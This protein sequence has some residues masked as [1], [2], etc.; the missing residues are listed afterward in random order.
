L[1]GQTF[2]DVEL[3]EELGQGGMGVVYK[4][5]QKSL[6]RLVAVKL[7]LAEHQ[8][9]AVRLARFQAEARAAASLNHSNIV[10][11]YQVGECSFGHYFA[12]EYIDGETLETIIQR[13]KIGIPTAVALMSKVAEAVHYAHSKGIVHRDLKPGNIMLDR[14][15]RPVVMD[16]GIAKFVGKSSRLTLEGAIMGTP[17]FM[18]PEQAGEAHDLVGPLSDVY[19]L[20]AVLY[21]LL[22]GRVPYDEGSTLRT[23]L[24]V[25]GPD[26]PPTVRSLR[27]QVPVELDQLCMKCLSKR[28]ADRYPSAQALAQELRRIRAGL[29]KAKPEAPGEKR[30]GRATMRSTLPSVVLVAEKSGKEMRLFHEQNII[31]RTSQCD[32]V[33]RAADVSKQHCQILIGPDDVVV[34]DLESANGTYLNGEAIQQAPLHD[35]DRL[36]IAGYEFLVRLVRPTS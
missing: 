23:V 2:G 10:Q 33:L 34:E 18:A 20:G 31:G 17:A 7:L 9:D 21:M 24:K 19:S 3:L 29:T 4:A 12:M 16:F 35:G 32:V 28:P 1:I 30:K 5:R 15:A 27:P 13:S 6:D 8:A 26:M 36:T 25:I 14:G 11:I 22:T